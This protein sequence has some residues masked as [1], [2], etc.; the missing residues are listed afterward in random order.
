MKERLKI[1]SFKLHIKYFKSNIN[2]FMIIILSFI[3]PAFL[4]L[5]YIKEIAFIANSK[6]A[7]GEII[8]KMYSPQQNKVSNYSI[9]YSFKDDVS[10]NI[11]RST[12]RIGKSRWNKLSEGDKVEIRYLK[13][14]PSDNKAWRLTILMDPFSYEFKYIL[15][16]FILTLFLLIQGLFLL[17]NL[18]KDFA[19]LK[20]LF[21]KGGQ[22]KGEIVET[23]FH[24]DKRSPFY[25]IKYG[26]KNF[27]KESFSGT[28]HYQTRYESKNIP[29]KGNKGTVFYSNEEPSDN[30][31]VGD[32][33]QK[34]LSIFRRIGVKN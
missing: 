3:L 26:F 14:K 31:W 18:K 19:A 24:N 10:G 20:R 9:V 25:E 16:Q 11:Y 27:N 15:F 7:Q 12:G 33:W 30:I 8:A 4:L 32:D 22:T 28:F 1:S 23:V 2:L 6:P 29:E 13:D 17:T 5:N 34:A 21:L